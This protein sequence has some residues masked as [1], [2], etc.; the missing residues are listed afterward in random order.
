MINIKS[1]K[2]LALILFYQSDSYGSH[3]NLMAISV[4]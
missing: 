2:Q 1:E 3:L 4:Y